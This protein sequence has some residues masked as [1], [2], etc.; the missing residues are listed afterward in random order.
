MS[1]RGRLAT[2]GTFCPNAD[3]PR[4]Q[5]V[6]DGNLIGYG[7]SRQGQQRYQGKVCQHVFNERVGTLFTNVFRGPVLTNRMEVAM[8]KIRRDAG[9]PL[10]DDASLLLLARQILRGPADHGRANY[11]MSVTVCEDC[12]RGWQT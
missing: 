4:Y 12:G 1:K 6:N 2:A 8:A 5:Q 3:C 10:D 11:Q 9:T 7:K